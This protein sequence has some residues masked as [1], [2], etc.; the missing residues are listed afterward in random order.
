MAW[1]ALSVSQFL[2]AG[3]MFLLAGALLWLNFESRLN[4]GFALFLLLRG[5]VTVAHRFAEAWPDSAVF[6]DDISEYLA[7][8]TTLALAYFLVTYTDRDRGA[9]HRV[10]VAGLVGVAALVE[11]L[12]LWDHCLVRCVSSE[13]AR[14]FGPLSFLTY[15]LTT[16]YAI[17][18]VVLARE[19]IRAAQP[20]RRQAAFLLAVAFLV[21][22]MFESLIVVGVAVAGAPAFVASLA[23]PS[24][25]FTLAYLLRGGAGLLA[26]VGFLIL[27]GPRARAIDATR[28]PRLLLALA[29]GAAAS[30]FYQGIIPNVLPSLALSATFL[31]GLWLLVLPVLVT[32]ALVRHRLFE[33]DVQLRWTIS[34]GPIAFGFLGAFFV[35]A[36][37]AQNYL[38]DEYG[39]IAGGVLAGLMLFALHPLQ[40]IGEKLADGVTP[41]AKPI[42][43]L[44]HDERLDIYRSQAALAWADGH[45][46]RKER[47]LLDSLRER[48]GIAAEDAL[49]LE[50][51]AIMSTPTA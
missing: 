41:R 32:Y 33:A 34:K 27:A 14:S 21:Q 19:S 25:W 31:T 4:R 37:V 8:G 7:I 1:E 23:D 6:W 50:R 42:S 9:R 35:G 49:V 36:Q 28:N 20:A 46:A 26:V 10:F 15:G 39:L 48:L 51:E 18:G 29:L 30:G 38:S 13:G 17:A 12:Y 47:F 43:K 5:G 44:T 24:V 3:L 22:S 45:L 11:G 40:R 16:L 2:A